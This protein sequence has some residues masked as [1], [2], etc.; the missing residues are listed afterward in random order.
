MA[1][2]SSTEIT[3]LL[4]A[5]KDGKQEA[6]EEL[7]PLIYQE[8]RGIA[9]RLLKK[10]S[11]KFTVQ[12]TDLVHEAYLRLIDENQLS[13]ENRAHF[14]AIAA[15]AMRQYLV[16]YARK[17]KAAK[18]GGGQFN[19]TL[20][21]FQLRSEQKSQEILALDEALSRLETFDPRMNKIVELRYF[22]G[23]TIQETATVLSISPATVKR[24]WVTAKAW[25][26][27]EMAG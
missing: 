23:L 3:R 14:F 24:E 6:L 20:N 26:Y 19:I 12:T 22:S 4:L 18:R 5:L 1:G 21:E 15:R 16:Y 17:S 8:L 27:N 9:S 25:L 13:W 7:T 10:E 11:G 2:K